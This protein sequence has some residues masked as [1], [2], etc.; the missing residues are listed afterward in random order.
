MMDRKLVIPVCC[1]LLV[2]LSGC[3]SSEDSSP[4]SVGQDDPAPLQIKEGQHTWTREGLPGEEQKKLLEVYLNDN[5]TIVE[6]P[7]IK[8]IPSLYTNEENHTRFYWFQRNADRVNWLYIE[9]DKNQFV[10][11]DEG[12]TPQD[13]FQ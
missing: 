5:S 9:F 6:N 11:L 3:F 7:L 8:G 1:A 13:E 4:V 12:L 10:S 2:S